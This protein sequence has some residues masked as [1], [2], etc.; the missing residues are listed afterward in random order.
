MKELYG[1]A[2]I[3]KNIGILLLISILIV[4]SISLGGVAY[5]DSGTDGS[6]SEVT[7]AGGNGTETDSYIIETAEQL[8]AVRNN[9]RASYRL[10]ADIEFTEADFAEG[11]K[12]YNDGKGWIPIN[13]FSGTF[14]GNGHVI[15]NIVINSSTNYTG[16]FGSCG[17]DAKIMNM[18]IENGDIIG[19]FCVGGIVAWI[20][21]GLIEKCY[22]SGIVNGNHTV[23]G[24]AGS[25]YG[26]TV[27]RAC[28]NTGSVTGSAVGGIVGSCSGEST[29]RDCYNT[30]SITG[31]YYAGGIVGNLESG[32]ILNCYNVGNVK[33]GFT[34]GEIAGTNNKGSITNCYYIE[35]KV[36]GVGSGADTATACL[37]EKFAVQ[38]TF[39]GFD[40]DAV[41]TIDG[42]GE[43]R[44]P[45]LQDL[46]NDVI[47]GL[48][49]NSTD[50][51]GGYG[52]KSSPYIVTNA[53]QLN[54]VR[55]Y[56]DA[57]FKLANDIEFTETDFTSGGDFYN[58]G[59]GW[60][61]IGTS[62]TPFTGMFDGNGHV[63]KGLQC[64][65]TTGNAG[66]FGY[67]AGAIIKLGI[68]S[69]AVKGSTAGSICASNSG[70][71][72]RCYNTCTVTASEAGG[73]TGY[74]QKTIKDCYN[75]GRISGS[76][77]AGGI[78]GNNNKY[79]SYL[80][81][82]VNC[83]NI[84]KIGCDTY[85][86]SIAGSNYN[87]A[88]INGCYYS[89]IGI[90]ASYHSENNAG[91]TSLA[92]LKKQE[93]YTEF[94]FDNTWTI[95]PE[96][97]Y[98]LPTLQGM[99]N[100][101]V[102][103]VENTTDFA[104]GYGTYDSPYIV[105]TTQQLDNIRKDLYASYRL[106]ND[107]TFEKKEFSKTGA[108][109]NE[110]NRWKPI[111]PFYGNLDGNGHCIRGL[112]IDRP[113][114][115]GCALFSYT[116]G[117]IKNLRVSEFKLSGRE[118]A[119][120][121]AYNNGIIDGCYN[122]DS[123][124]FIT[125]TNSENDSVTDKRIG[126]FC[127][128]N[129]GTIRN[130]YNL[131]SVE[132][133][134][135]AGGITNYNYGIIRK[136]YNAGNIT[137]SESGAGIAVHSSG[138]IYDC[139]NTGDVNSGRYA[140][141]I[142]YTAKSIVTSYNL[143]TIMAPILKNNTGGIVGS[144]NN[145]SKTENCYS[146]D[147]SEA[148]NKGSEYGNICTI[149]QMIKRETYK[150]FDFENIWE[151]DGSDD[152]KFPVLIGVSNYA[153]A[154]VEDTTDFAGGYGTKSKPYIIENKTQLNNVRKKMNAC[155]KLN[156]DIVFS[157][158]DFAEG[159]MFYNDGKGWEP[160]GDAENIFKGTFNGNGHTISGL[161]I[162][163]ND[164]E[165]IG[166]FG[167]SCG[168]I[169]N[170]KISGCSISGKTNVGGIAGYIDYGK[171]TN[172][173]TAGVITACG[174]ENGSYNDFYKLGGVAGVVDKS[175]IID[176]VNYATVNAVSKSGRAYGGGI[177][178]Y[179]SSSS[180]ISN[181]SN[182][183]S[184]KNLSEEGRSDLGGIV[185][186]DS[187]GGNIESCYNA[188]NIQGFSKEA[189][190]GGLV[191]IELEGTVKNSY[192][193][194]NIISNNVAGGI[195][196]YG[197]DLQINGCYNA[198]EISA[199]SV[200]EDNG[201]YDKIVGGIIGAVE[202]R[203][204]MTNCYNI[205]SV[206]SFRGYAGGIMGQ[207]FDRHNSVIDTCYNVGTVSCHSGNAGGIAGKSEA[208]ISDCFYLDNISKGVGSGT[209]AATKCSSADMQ[210]EETYGDAFDFDY[211]MIWAIS[212]TAEY[213]YPV[214]TEVVN[215]EFQYTLSLESKQGMPDVPVAVSYGNGKITV[216]AVVG[217]KYVCVADSEA[218]ESGMIPALSSLE[219]KIAS[220]AILTFEGLEQ[221]RTYRI[222]TYIPAAGG[223]SA[224]YVSQP[225]VVTLKE[226][227]DLSG[228]GKIDSSDA[229]YLRRAFAGW[230]GYELNF[231]AADINADG[232]LSADDIMILER[233]IAGWSSYKTLPVR[234]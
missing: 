232:K 96:D 167:Y 175:E 57:S 217:Q 84:G 55:N 231:S 26:G 208:T 52:I 130:C 61:A 121:T 107:I 18:G 197:C 189:N 100:Y 144:L 63:I 124:K 169:K 80:C 149:A 226:V 172:C 117:E 170:T 17:S 206:T 43:Y 45:T 69:G 109:Y 108:F 99:I 139:Y 161:Q 134:D 5:A 54:N 128:K 65:Q 48:T 28:Y 8:D 152:Y 6:G 72:S 81:E 116:Y 196:G 234:K 228:D 97:D 192:N 70:L 37:L 201:W 1:G 31:E 174:K 173:D 162:T 153:E 93:T 198:G 115:Y 64:K 126:I 88:V 92:E 9:L 166:L 29:I 183:G 66:L 188:G 191:G 220:D 25:C 34:L 137:A 178:G 30:A 105:K 184:V 138:K 11:G 53:Q 10:N 41:W 123:V 148:Y 146:L 193:I 205:G 131:G 120:I 104:G 33:K 225:L 75:S 102:A 7:F 20:K 39:E 68:V 145:G 212:G 168:T 204:T 59:K 118:S 221:G 21:G 129:W 71:I 223:K 199:V 222:Y 233:Y 98:W 177:V 91:A 14:D 56:L 185:G 227:G 202:I 119:C 49:E 2:K 140:G 143:G 15:R 230:D 155:Y 79:S 141:G 136:C 151:F 211:D 40:F 76:K 112:I 58:D 35:G 182:Y 60:E 36:P 229:F 42:N 95:A 62:S 122:T 22:Y 216:K 147:T 159:G 103:P 213:K 150:G 73:I 94:D 111:T 163:R 133:S 51:A 176:C 87:N 164:E 219:W 132:T 27:I 85:R 23:G 24:I 210:N 82:I 207:S 44:F 113:D 19:D 158:A 154:P 90:K 114:E 215:P 101:A 165:N 86:G 194:G 181:C 110:G 125:N 127:Y 16:F 46:P 74:N 186:Y 214:L 187:R 4:T 47:F 200:E 77:Y 38:A 89:N 12:F 13:N 50:F 171:V 195:V 78:V 32:K 190:I 83:Y 157:A 156:A 180:K 67:N 218:G 160:I 3:K 224:S 142:A 135:S 203:I 179:N 209:D 106:E